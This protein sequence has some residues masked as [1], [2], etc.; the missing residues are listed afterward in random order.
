[1]ELFLSLRLVV[2]VELI[3]VP[4]DR[5]T[6]LVI[7]VIAPVSVLLSVCVNLG[8]GIFNNSLNHGVLDVLVT[9]HVFEV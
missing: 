1:V 7:G 3:K 9:E 8:G 4:S 5:T 6:S 2:H